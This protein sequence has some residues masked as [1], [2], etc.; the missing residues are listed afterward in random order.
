MNPSTTIE[1]LFEDNHLMWVNWAYAIVKNRM[2]AEDIVSESYVALWKSND[3]SNP[4]GFLKVA[5][6]NR[7]FNYLKGNKIRQNTPPP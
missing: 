1:K 4:N 2:E 6:Q 7:C 3:W 5:I